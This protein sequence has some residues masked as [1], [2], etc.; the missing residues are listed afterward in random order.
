[1]PHR[2]ADEPARI[3]RRIRRG[4]AA[5]QRHAAARRARSPTP[6]GVPGW[7]GIEYMAQAAPRSPA[8][9]RSSA[10]SRPSIGLLIGAR[11]YR[12][13]QDHYP[14]RH[15][16]RRRR[17]ARAA[18]RP[19]T[20]PPTTARSS[21]HGQRIAECTLKAYRPRD[22]RPVLLSGERA[23]ADTI[24]VTGS[25]RGIGRAIALR[26]AQDGYALVVHGRA[27]SPALDS[28]A[29]GPVLAPARPPGSCTSTS[30]IARP[31]PARSRP[32]S[33]RTARITA[34]SATRGSRA[35]A[36]FRRSPARTGTRCSAPTWTVSIT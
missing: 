12:C 4:L 1:M 6:H 22:I 15:H 11:Y 24:L 33:P 34:W 23:V 25:S 16:A 10:A 35:T 26:L 8:S 21:S 7:V 14:V 2:G 17:E 18:R 3:H 20:S 32:T 5:R 31:R 28:N 19:R 13:M 30:P 29:R 9:S 27:P 36:R